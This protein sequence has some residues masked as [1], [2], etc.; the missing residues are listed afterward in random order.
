M[1]SALI[2]EIFFFQGQ[3]HSAPREGN[4]DDEQAP[5]IDENFDFENFV[6]INGSLHYK[7]DNYYVFSCDLPNDIHL[8]SNY[9]LVLFCVIVVFAVSIANC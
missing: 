6:L 9:C 3:F 2:F 1:R 5:N 4:M 7:C 8:I